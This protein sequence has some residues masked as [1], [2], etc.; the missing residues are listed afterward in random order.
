MEEVTSHSNDFGIFKI[1]ITVKIRTFKFGQNQNKRL[2]TVTD[3]F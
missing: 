2:S 1:T 3:K